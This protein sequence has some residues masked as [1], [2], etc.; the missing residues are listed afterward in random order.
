ME[1]TTP[2]TTTALPSITPENFFDRYH[3][4]SVGTELDLGPTHCSTVFVLADKYMCNLGDTMDYAYMVADEL[5]GELIEDNL[6]ST[7]DLIDWEAYEEDYLDED[8]RY[9]I[10]YEFG[11]EHSD[12]WAEALDNW[13]ELVRVATYSDEW[14]TLVVGAGYEQTHTM[15]MMVIDVVDARTR[16]MMAAELAEV[17]EGND[18]PN[19]GDDVNTKQE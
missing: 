5:R 13:D 11:L 2:T 19:C 14:S 10:M 12:S 7:E 3:V 16:T 6:W 4:V 15:H 17:F 18:T 8:A 9:E 1:N